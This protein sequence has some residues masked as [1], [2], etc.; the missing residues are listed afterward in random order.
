[1]PR[2][3]VRDSSYRSP[4]PG[5]GRLEGPAKQ[6]ASVVALLI[7]TALVLPYSVAIYLGELKLTPIKILI[8]VL[9]LP[10]MFSLIGSWSN[11]RRKFLASDAYAF[12]VFA[13]MSLGPATT[14]GSRD[15]VSAFSQAIEFYGVYIVA[16]AYLN[17]LNSI[18][19]L[20]RGLQ[21]AT[22][23]VVALGV[24]DFLS[25]RY[26]TQDLANALFSVGSERALNAS[27]S[28]LNRTVLGMA[29]LRAA[30]TFDHP[31]LFG[32]FCVTVLPLY[33]YSPMSGM[34]RF[35]LIGACI[36]GSLVALSSAPLLGLSM[37]VAVYLYDLIFKTQRWR[38]KLLLT[39][40]TAFIVTFSVASNNPLSWLFRNLTFDPQTA[41]F[42][43]LM[44]EIGSTIIERNF[45][46]GVGYNPIGDRILESSIDSLMLAKAIIYGVPMVVFLYLSAICAYLPVRG[47][48][49]I[50]RQ[51]PLLDVRC[52]GFSLTLSTIMFISI[53]VTFWNAVWLFFAL[54]IAVRA[55]LKEQCLVALRNA[56]HV[57]GRAH[58]M[59]RSIAGPFPAR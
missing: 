43:L 5:R 58:Q 52:T 25:H 30:S 24:L 45:W 46:F 21:V 48:Q 3:A 26:I 36:T 6:K 11:G 35:V 16:R 4:A 56:A 54:C 27:E 22:M 47:E 2:L 7:S 57:G 10:A 15:L 32:A 44:W 29:S 13:L 40:I 28:Q 33:L 49:A 20:I 34:R 53:T 59:R 23:V 42:R 9:M 39:C 14:S 1:M 12:G 19:R 8:V 41:Y 31:I 18:E 37:V 55:S 50:R 38:W 51:N 17:D